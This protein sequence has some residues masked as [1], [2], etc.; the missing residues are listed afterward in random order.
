M[1]NTHRAVFCIQLSYWCLW[2]LDWIE[3]TLEGASRSLTVY[4]M[5]RG[6]LFPAPPTRSTLSGFMAE[7]QS[8]TSLLLW[9]LVVVMMCFPAGASFSWNPK[10]P[11]PRTPQMV[12]PS[13]ASGP[14]CANDNKAHVTG[15][16]CQPQ[17]TQWF[18]KFVI[19]DIFFSYK[20]KN[21]Q[22]Y[23]Y[24]DSKET[25]NLSW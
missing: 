19:M 4:F 11:K 7:T 1:C 6:T 17:R 25:K 22:C 14:A 21:T 18:T 10:A 16:R 2:R 13:T 15:E 3:T 20:S 5:C 24:K 12:L 8:V 23:K 9:D